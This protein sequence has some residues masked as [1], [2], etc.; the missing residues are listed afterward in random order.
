MP[1]TKAPKA[2]LSIKSFWVLVAVIV[3]LLGSATAAWGFVFATKEE[4]KKVELK[5]ADTGRDK[6]SE[7]RIQSIEI[8]M[9]NL[10][11]RVQKIDKNLVALLERFR[12]ISVPEP[13]YKMMPS[14][15]IPKE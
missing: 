14:R 12:V 4:L 6:V 3:G 11:A 10:D 5:Q 1:D 8:R 2:N 7:W 9:D 15:P 13:S